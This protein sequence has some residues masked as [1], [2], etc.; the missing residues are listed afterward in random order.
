[1][2]ACL[3]R[4]RCTATKQATQRMICL[5]WIK[6]FRYNPIELL[7]RLNVYENEAACEIVVT[8]LHEAIT[9]PDDSTMMNML[10][11][12]LSDNEIRD[13]RQGMKDATNISITVTKRSWSDVPVG[14]AAFFCKLGMQ[15]RNHA[16]L[17][18][19]NLRPWRKDHVASFAP[20]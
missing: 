13:F 15:K 4:Y 6:A 2:F 3:S 9:S 18:T 12:E 19:N 5:G 8:A 16:W 1:M 10:Q 11:E 7:R 14:G 20:P 17:A